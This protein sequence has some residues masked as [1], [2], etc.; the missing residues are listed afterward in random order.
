L[1][2]A[3]QVFQSSNLSGEYHLSLDASLMLV[4]LFQSQSQTAQ[5]K[6]YTDFIQKNATPQ[7]RRQHATE[8]T[9]LGID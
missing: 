4:K 9:A 1:S 2:V 8:M 7:W 6:K 5:S 3:E